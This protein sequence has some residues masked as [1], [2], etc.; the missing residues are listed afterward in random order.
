LILYW[1]NLFDEGLYS[2]KG[3]VFNSLISAP[4]PRWSG[5]S[6]WETRALCQIWHPSQVFFSDKKRRLC[7]K[8]I[9]IKIRYCNWICLKWIYSCTL[10][11]LTPLPSIFLSLN[12]RYEMSLLKSSP[13][14]C[15]NET[16][17]IV[18]SSISATSGRSADTF[19]IAT[20]GRD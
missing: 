10:A 14:I 6:F 19:W 1:Y 16:S 18:S 13:G 8:N 12:S 3:D 7:P 11:G 9:I 15:P 4:L 5:V 2:G 20:S 17:A